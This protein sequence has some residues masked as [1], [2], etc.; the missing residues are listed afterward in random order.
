MPT[1]LGAAMLALT[2]VRCNC[3]AGADNCSVGAVRCFND[4]D[5][6]HPH[7]ALFEACEPSPFNP[8]ISGWSPE[9]CDFLGD[10]GSQSNCDR[11]N[12]VC[13]DGYCYCPPV[14]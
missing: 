6:P 7:G 11:R 5:Y 12:T 8:K 14:H 4:P 13:W 1:L 2:G 10:G 9:F 3:G